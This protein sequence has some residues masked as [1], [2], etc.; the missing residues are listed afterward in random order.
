MTVLVELKA[1]GDEVANIEWAKRLEDSGIHVVYGIMGLK[2]HC[3]LSML[4]RR[5]QD[6]LR[7][8]A[9]LGTG[10]YNHTTARLYTDLGLITAHPELTAEVAEVFNLL[11]AHNREARFKRLLV[12]PAGLMQGMLDRIDR[13]SEQARAGRPAAIIAKMN[14]LMD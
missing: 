1:R 4:V 9:H 13:E 6:R 2:T 14:G 3:K 10:N 7:R 5:D 12:A 8:Y 11:T